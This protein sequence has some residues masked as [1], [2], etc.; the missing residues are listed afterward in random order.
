[1]PDV[2]RSIEDSADGVTTRVQGFAGPGAPYPA[3]GDNTTQGLRFNNITDGI[4]R[5]IS[6][7]EVGSDHAVPWTK[8]ADTSFN[9]N[10]PLSALGDIST[11]LL[12][13]MFDGS[14]QY[15]S[16]G[17]SLSELKALI[18]YNGGEDTTHPP[19]VATIPAIYVHQSAGDTRSNEFGADW[20]DVVL[21]KAP[22]SS[23]VLSV[24]LSNAALATVDKATVTFTPENWKVP[25]RVTFRP[26]DNHVVGPDAEVEI[27][28]AVVAAESA[29]AYDSVANK[30][31]TATITDDD[32]GPALA[33]DYNLDSV[34]DAADY[35]VW[36]D[37]LG[38]T[39]LTPFSGA[40][41]DGDGRVTANDR[42]VWVANFGSRLEASLQA[43][44]ASGSGAAAV[45]APAVTEPVEVAV[46]RL[47]PPLS[48]N[49][50][51]TERESESA[52]QVSTDAILV[53]PRDEAL[54]LLT[55]Q[56]KYELPT[57][58]IPAN[59]L[60]AWVDAALA[61]EIELF[62]LG[63]EVKAALGGVL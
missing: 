33:G 11:V 28:V 42:S 50:S 5:T 41:G 37:S 26:V 23:V 9:P 57:A 14:V 19:A 43:V 25:Q 49:V 6:F 55:S 32:A 7:I 38:D 62:A 30:V 59:E 47:M 31:F 36:R 17:I 12:T 29:N 52:P 61:E 46:P 8:P 58:A 35:S 2:F 51:G 60:A 21:D 27:T 15:R 1:M 39:G 22:M 63:D 24:G 45:M 16:G 3:T 18:T 54:Q 4:S 53:A 10:N 40:D 56:R 44:G 20:F 48:L 34:V 13:G